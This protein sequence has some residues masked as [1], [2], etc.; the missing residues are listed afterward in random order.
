MNSNSSIHSTDNKY[1][2]LIL[3]LSFFLFY[4]P[5]YTHTFLLILNTTIN[6]ISSCMNNVVYKCNVRTKIIFSQ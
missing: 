2:L 6:L 1:Y 5:M 4:I 3:R